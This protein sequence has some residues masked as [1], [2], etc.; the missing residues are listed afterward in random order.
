MITNVITSVKNCREF[1]EKRCVN[2]D[3]DAK[4]N[5]CVYYVKK[6]KKVVGCKIPYHFKY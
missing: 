1:C 3:M 6:H 5:R 2:P 4:T